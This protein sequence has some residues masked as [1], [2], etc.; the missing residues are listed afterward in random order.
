VIVIADNQSESD[1]NSDHEEH[2]ETK[3]IEDALNSELVDGPKLQDSGLRHRELSLA[4]TVST[5]SSI[6]AMNQPTQEDNS[7][8]WLEARVTMH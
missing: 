4:S 1:A 7:D 5:E 2:Y 6:V 8:T 3:A